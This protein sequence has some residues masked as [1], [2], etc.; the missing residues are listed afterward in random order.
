MIKDDE[1]S[2]KLMESQLLFNKSINE[3]VIDFI[4][5]G[6]SR[7]DSLFIELCFCI[8]TANT[9]ADM[10][11]KTQRTIGNGF[12]EYDQEKL[13]EELKKAKYRFYNK[14]ADYIVNARHV[15]KNIKKMMKT[16]D[17]FS[18]REYLVNNIKG[19]GYKEASHFL[20]NIG[21][22]DFAILDKHIMQLLKDYGYI[23]NMKLNTRS[24]YL[25]KEGIFNEIA[26]SYNMR[27]GIL[28]LYLWQIATGKI[29]K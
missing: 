5:M 15:R 12:I 1:L 8:L 6:K 2:I 24:D 28:D 23:D 17:H 21:I 11:I 20:R 3:R 14:R 22:F 26:E 25:E 19:I 29:L 13:S 16:M 7:N 10:G 27:P 18:L 4:N 9:S